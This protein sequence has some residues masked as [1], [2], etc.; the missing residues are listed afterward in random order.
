[1]ERHSNL[2][3][4][5]HHPSFGVLNDQ[6]I[7]SKPLSSKQMEIMRLLCEGRTTKE[8]SKEIGGSP[9]TIETHI[10]AIFYKLNAKNRS[11]AV[12]IFSKHFGKFFG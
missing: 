6:A 12:F 1:M 11:H 9:N 4:I 8:I 3:M 10:K 2:D 5:D 7:V